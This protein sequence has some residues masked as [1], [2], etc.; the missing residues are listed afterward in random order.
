MKISML[1]ILLEKANLSEESTAIIR[2]V[3]DEEHSEEL[4][5]VQVERIERL[6]EGELALSEKVIEAYEGIEHSLERV[7]EGLRAEQ[8]SIQ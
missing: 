3:L 4:S 5:D 6:L 7:V 8:K 1:R 2:S